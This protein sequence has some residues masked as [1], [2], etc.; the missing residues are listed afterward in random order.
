MTVPAREYLE[1]MG[2]LK[3]TPTSRDPAFDVPDSHV[4]AL[5]VACRDRGVSLDRIVDW[6]LRK[7]ILTVRGDLDLAATA[8]TMFPRPGWVRALIGDP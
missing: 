2:F 7:L 3:D 1:P 8:V 4:L 6:P 5:R